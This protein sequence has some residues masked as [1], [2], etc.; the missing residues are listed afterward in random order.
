MA[1]KNSIIN[2][3]IHLIADITDFTD[4]SIN[5]DA[6]VAEWGGELKA[7]YARTD[8][9]EAFDSDVTVNGNV[10]IGITNP[11]FIQDNVIAASGVALRLRLHSASSGGQSLI[12]F[13]NTTNNNANTN[14]SAFIGSERVGSDVELIFGTSSGGGTSSEK[15]RLDKSGNLSVTGKGDFGDD[16]S[17]TT[18]GTYLQADLASSLQTRIHGINPSDLEYIGSIDQTVVG[19]FVGNN[20]GYVSLRTAS[21]ER[22]RV[23]DTIVNFKV[24]VDVDGNITA[25]I[26]DVDSYLKFSAAGATPSTTEEAIY[27]TS[28]NLQVQ[29][30][31][32][33]FI[34]AD[35]DGS[36]SGVVD[37]TTK[38]TSR[39]R[40]HNEGN[41]SIGN[42]TDEGIKLDVLDEITGDVQNTVLKLKTKST[43]DNIGTL[44]CDLDFFMEDNNTSTTLPQGRIGTIGS[45]VTSQDAEAGGRIT[46]SVHNYDRITEELNEAMRIDGEFGY[47]SIG[48]TDAEEML[49][50][51]ENIKAASF[52]AD[53]K[54]ADDILLG[55]GATTSLAAITSEID[56]KQDKSITQS[57]VTDID[58]SKTAGNQVNMAAANGTATYTVTGS[59][60]GG[61][62][63]VLYDS[64]GDTEFPTV[65]GATSTAGS[66]FEADIEY[67][68]H[69]TD[70]G[71]T[72]G[73]EY[74]FVRL[75]ASSGGGGSS[76]QCDTNQ[77]RWQM[78]ST[79][80]WV[81][82]RSQNGWYDNNSSYGTGT[83]PSF[84]GIDMGMTILPAGTIL[85]K[86]EV[87]SNFNNNEID[88]ANIAIA[89]LGSAS[90]TGNDYDT[91]SMNQQD[92]IT[93]TTLNIPALA[94]DA[95][96]HVID[97]A[98]VTLDYYS[99]IAVSI[100]PIGT[101][102]GTRYLG[103]TMRLYYTLP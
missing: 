49:H 64:T 88:G 21:T 11:Q 90:G 57:G 1:D 58:M 22:V 84:N 47:V 4:N 48:L 91:G 102:T 41:V 34:Q 83:E 10:G 78:F 77:G 60:T 12:Q 30:S 52:I 68:M 74:Y 95:H 42:A 103:T 54:T 65:T 94:G 93:S 55:T 38:N 18:N 13:T 28:G 100:S 86:I 92:I 16:I 62:A 97:F 82:P 8:I 73:I 19:T 50:V 5:W 33:I 75:E 98:D 70:Y 72:R 24:D 27:A 15:M 40:I 25:D 20:T 44:S 23:N 85:H 29:G 46:F 2:N 56:T 63:V 67:H 81:G 39:L 71:A 35:R 76:I 53:G 9:A 87:L 99:S 66:T 101:L 36:G 37:L 6:L 89:A 80:G 31:S 43:S 26:Y 79:N 3:R 59:V 45:A 17:L 61:N 14:H 32:T 69:I 96:V 51:S 7:N